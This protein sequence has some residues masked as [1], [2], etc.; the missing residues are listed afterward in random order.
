MSNEMV[1]S[2]GFERPRGANKPYRYGVVVLQLVAT[3]TLA[4]STAVAAT[5][6]T[7]GYARA[8]TINAV[9]DAGNGRFGLALFFG[10][11]FFGMGGLTALMARGHTTSK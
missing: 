1:A 11:L 2:V 10:L 6:V 8:E 3:L 9:A 5:I 4:L 7:I